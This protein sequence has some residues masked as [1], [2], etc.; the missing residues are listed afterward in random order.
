MSASQQAPPPRRT[1][2]KIP[3][4]HLLKQQLQEESRIISDQAIKEA[5]HALIQLDNDLHRFNLAALYIQSNRSRDYIERGID[6]IADLLNSEHNSELLSSHHHGHDGENGGGETTNHYKRD[7]MYF[8]AL[9]FYHL[10]DYNNSRQWLHT[11]LRYDSE[12]RQARIMLDL[13][14]E[15][16]HDEGVKG[17]AIAGGAVAGGVL[18]VAGIVAL[19]LLRR[20]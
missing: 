6:Y 11:L 12:N 16:I 18:A 9:G 5:E 15:K 10:H 13:V 7:C 1:T 3:P 19:A 8:M 20:N 14:N 17:L 4:H 2:T